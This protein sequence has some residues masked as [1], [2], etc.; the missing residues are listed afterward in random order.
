MHIQVRRAIAAAAVHFGTFET[1]QFFKY[2]FHFQQN[3]RFTQRRH[4]VVRNF[5]NDSTIPLRLTI[6]INNVSFYRCAA[7]CS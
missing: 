1:Y 6:I 4:Q 2:R 3:I 5:R 7:D